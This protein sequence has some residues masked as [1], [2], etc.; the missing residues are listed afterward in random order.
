M[1]RGRQAKEEAA[2]TDTYVRRDNSGL[3]SAPIRADWPITLC[4]Q[5]L[6]LDTI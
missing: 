4:A 5:S 3:V 2:L 1:A 6:N